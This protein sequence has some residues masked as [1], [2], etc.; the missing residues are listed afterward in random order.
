MFLLLS[1]KIFFNILDVLFSV[2]QSY[3]TLPPHGL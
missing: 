1:Y 2:T 3:L